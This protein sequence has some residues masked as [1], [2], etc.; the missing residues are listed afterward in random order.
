MFDVIFPR[1]RALP[2]KVNYVHKINNKL[3]IKLTSLKT[4]VDSK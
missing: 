4:A 3:N 2:F 1:A